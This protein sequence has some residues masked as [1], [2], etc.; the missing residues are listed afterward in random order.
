MYPVYVRLAVSSVSSE[1]SQKVAGPGAIKHGLHNARLSDM[2]RGFIGAGACYCVAMTHNKLLGYS[3]LAMFLGLNSHV[4]V[5]L[6][7][8]VGFAAFWVWF[9]ADIY[10]S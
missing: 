9:I 8:L 7:G 5:F 4:S 10:R 3:L 2:L 6:L 1:G